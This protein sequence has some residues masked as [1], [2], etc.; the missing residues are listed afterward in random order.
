VRHVTLELTINTTFN[1]TGSIWKTVLIMWITF[2]F[3]IEA[4]KEQSTSLLKNFYK[5][6][7]IEIRPRYT[8]TN[9]VW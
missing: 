2:S 4:A 9:F 7:F 6:S 5:L 8:Y 1:T 3:I